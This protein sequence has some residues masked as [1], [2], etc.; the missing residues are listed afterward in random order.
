[1]TA[2]L[3]RRFIREADR[4]DDPDVRAA[5]GTLAAVPGIAVNQLLSA[6]K[7]LMGL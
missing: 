3:I 6:G 7:C 5:Y 4:G 1:M 2:W